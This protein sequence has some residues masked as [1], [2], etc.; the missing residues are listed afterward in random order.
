MTVRNEGWRLNP[1]HKA[2][3]KILQEMVVDNAH[4]AGKWAGICGDGGGPGKLQ[5]TFSAWEFD[6]IS[7]AP[8]HMKLRKDCSGNEDNNKLYKNVE[9]HLIGGMVIFLVAFFGWQRK[10][11]LS[12]TL[13][14]NLKDSPRKGEAAES[15]FYSAQL[16]K[17]EQEVYLFLKETWS[18]K[19]QC[20]HS[21]QQRKR[22]QRILSTLEYEGTF[23][24]TAL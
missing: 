15:T 24:F 17:K 1:H 2:I 13:L 20:C 11:T 9:K 14:Q 23:I 7:V 10:L 3:L 5:K 22:Y 18:R 21:A 12:N 8:S 6:E 4:A 16:T 19:G